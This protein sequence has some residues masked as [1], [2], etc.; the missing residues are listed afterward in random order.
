MNPK[1]KTCQ[2][3]FTSADDWQNNARVNWKRDQIELFAIGYK[4]AADILVNEVFK[5]RCALDF[6]IY[7]IVFLYRHYIELRLKEIIQE[8][9]KII[10]EP[11]NF[12]MHHRLLELWQNAKPILENVF[13][14]ETDIPDYKFIENIITE[15]SKFDPESFLFRYPIDKQGNNTLS[16]LTHIN[17][18]HLAEIMAKLGKELDNV[19]T[20]ISIYRDWQTDFY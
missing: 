12:P 14:N 4:E 20:G 10:A 16:G 19:S 15:F 13:E 1:S 5:S 18:R 8:G 7:P 11:G 3:L 2:P 6:L 9:R 17:V